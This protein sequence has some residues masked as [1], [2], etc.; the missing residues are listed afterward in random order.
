MDIEGAE[1][2]VVNDNIAILSTFRLIILE[3]HPS[4]IGEKD[5]DEIRSVFTCSGFERL[6]EKSCVEAW[7]K[8]C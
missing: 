6:G 2:F 5:C 7:R 8:I 3:L 4:L 1:K